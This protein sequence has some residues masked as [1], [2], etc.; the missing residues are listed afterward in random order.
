MLSFFGNRGQVQPSQSTRKAAQ[1]R[2]ESKLKS[3]YNKKQNKEERLKRLNERIKTSKSEWVRL[4]QY[5]RKNKTL[6]VPVIT[7]K[8]IEKMTLNEILAEIA[9]LEEE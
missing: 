4:Q 8:D 7:F 3:Q 1:K 2:L 9:Q 6:V 5:N